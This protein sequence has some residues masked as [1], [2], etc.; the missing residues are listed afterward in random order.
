MASECSPQHGSSE[1]R[2]Q[3]LFLAGRFEPYTKKGVFSWG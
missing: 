1:M 2:R 3:E